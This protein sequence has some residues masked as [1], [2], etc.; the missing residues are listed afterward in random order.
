M[1]LSHDSGNDL[2]RAAEITFRR[3]LDFLHTVI[4]GVKYYVTICLPSK[5]H[6]MFTWSASLRPSRYL[7][8]GWL[9]MPRISEHLKPA[10]LRHHKARGIFT[11]CR[12]ASQTAD[13]LTAAQSKGNNFLSH[14]SPNVIEGWAKEEKIHGFGICR[15]T[16]TVFLFPQTFMFPSSD[17]TIN[18][19]NLKKPPSK[20]RVYKTK[21]E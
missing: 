6:I 20:L 15:I 5:D 1:K 18:L 17:L 7:T 2:I 14:S 9:L 8:L 10:N 21:H 19:K 12:W 16:Y 13:I 11:N 4:C 3:R